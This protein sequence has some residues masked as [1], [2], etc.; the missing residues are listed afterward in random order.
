MTKKIKRGIDITFSVFMSVMGFIPL[1]I[2]CLLI[3]IKMGRPIFFT[4]IRAGKDGRPFKIYKFRTMKNN[5][6]RY[7][8]LLE[9][10][11]RKDNFG[12]ILRKYSL[13]ELPQIINILKGDISLVGPRP[14][15]MEYNDLY[16]SEQKRRLYVRP[17]L[18]GWAQV[19]GR[20]AISW[21]KKFYYDVWYV[22]NWSLMLDVKIIL[23]TIKKVLT[24]DGVNTNS[25]QMVKRFTGKEDE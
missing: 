17:G 12:N 19:N 10:N 23:L 25:N 24:S 14:L 18:T 3:I 9:N 22:D 8:M 11:L 13:D 15:L 21:N 7:G 1:L 4:Q 2:I 20:N 6:D 16:S 5:K